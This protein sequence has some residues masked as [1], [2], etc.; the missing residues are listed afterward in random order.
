MH[1]DL[2]ATTVKMVTVLEVVGLGTEGGF[3][4]LCLRSPACRSFSYDSE[5]S[6]YLEYKEI[7]V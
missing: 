2:P 1:P 4:K 7:Y 3:R 5:T 6:W